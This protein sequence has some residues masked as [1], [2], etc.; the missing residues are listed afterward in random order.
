MNDHKIHFTSRRNSAYYVQAKSCACCLDDRC[1]T[2]QRLG[3][4]RVRIRSNSGLILEKDNGFLFLDT[5]LNFWKHLFFPLCYRFWISLI[6]TIERFLGGK[7]AKLSQQTTNRSC[8]ELDAV[9]TFNQIDNHGSGPQSKFKFHLQR[10]FVSN[11]LVY[12]FDLSATEL[13]WAPALA[14]SAQSMP[15]T[16]AIS[17]RP[18]VYAWLGK[19]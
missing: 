8:A 6:R 3:F 10:I 18:V 17:A 15:P 9:L 11:R 13:F 7:K 12:P 1:F 19:S 4:A 2:F 16:V 5:F 14:P